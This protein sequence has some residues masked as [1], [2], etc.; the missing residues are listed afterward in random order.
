V[1]EFIF[2]LSKDDNIINE[3]ITDDADEASEDDFCHATLEPGRCVSKTKWDAVESVLSK[4]SDKCGPLASM[5]GEAELMVA[6]TEIE[7]TVDG[8]TGK[9]WEN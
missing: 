1:E 3:D 7:G 2:R 9:I 8:V 5:R 6:R 4:R